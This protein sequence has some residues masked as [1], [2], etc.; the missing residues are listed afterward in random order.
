MNTQGLRI[1]LRLITQPASTPLYSF[2]ENL[3]RITSRRV[4]FH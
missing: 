3:N 1:D 2:C 4:L